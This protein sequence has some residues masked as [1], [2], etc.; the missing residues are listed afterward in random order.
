MHMDFIIL[1]E[2]LDFFL[3]LLEVHLLGPDTDCFL[4][5]DSL[6]FHVKTRAAKLSLDFSQEEQRVENFLPTLMLPSFF[7]KVCLPRN[8]PSENFTF[9]KCC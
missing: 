6:T 4:S 8:A 7:S 3:L 9:V 5:V 2:S 1:K